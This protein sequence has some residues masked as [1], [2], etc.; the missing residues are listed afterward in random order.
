M[1][2]PAQNNPFNKLGISGFHV[3]PLDH[4]SIVKSSSEMLPSQRL[5]AQCDKQRLYNS[6]VSCFKVADITSVSDQSESFSFTM[7]WYKGDPVVIF[8]DKARPAQIEDFSKDLLSFISESLR[9]AVSKVVPFELV[10]EKSK[11][12]SEK[13]LLKHGGSHGTLESLVQYHLQSL[14][15]H[16]R[17]FLLPLGPCHGD[18]TF[19]NMLFPRNRREYILIDFLDVYF[20]SPVH[21][22][23]KIRQETKLRWSSILVDGSIGHDRGKYSL[24]MKKIDGTLETY[25]KSLDLYPL[26]TIFECQNLLR[27]LAYSD[28]NSIASAVIKRMQSL[29]EGQS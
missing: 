17:G 26:L 21:D 7:P 6:P 13:A 16:R 14:Q 23:C 3:G 24:I 18:L 28:S 15:A 25:V 1:T 20:E 5:R 22:I 29:K 11:N 19:S 4:C 2:T 9:A 27:I 12:A 8:V 10:Q